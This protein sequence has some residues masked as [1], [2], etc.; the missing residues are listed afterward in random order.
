M[1]HTDAD[2]QVVHDA[3]RAKVL[4]YLQRL[5]GPT[6]AEDLVQVVM[7]KVSQ[8]LPGFR[9]ESGRSTWI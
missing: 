4:R 7:L 6:E 5:V 9:G 1:P 2:F 3:F 8:G